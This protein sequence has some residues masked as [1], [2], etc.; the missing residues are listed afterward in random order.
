MYQ[1][2][3]KFKAPFREQYYDCVFYD[4]EGDAVD[5]SNYLKSFDNYSDIRITPNAVDY[6]VDANEEIARLRKLLSNAYTEL[7]QL[8]RDYNEFLRNR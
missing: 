4:S 1:V 8:K 3:F 7:Q 5:Y 2:S 6:L